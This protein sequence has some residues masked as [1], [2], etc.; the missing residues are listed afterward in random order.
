[1]KKIF[2]KAKSIGLTWKLLFS[3]MLVTMFVVCFL[4]VVALMVSKNILVS[5]VSQYNLE[6][7]NQ[8]RNSVELILDYM[9]ERLNTLYVDDSFMSKFKLYCN[10]DKRTYEEEL[11]KS[12]KMLNDY[13]ALMDKLVK[14]QLPMKFD[15]SYMFA[16]TN[17]AVAY[18]SWGKPE[19]DL[20]GFTEDC[21]RLFQNKDNQIIWLT[22]HR[23][24][25][26]STFFYDDTKTFS[27]IKRISDIN[28]LDTLG[29]MVISISEK[30]LYNCYKDLIKKQYG[31]MIYIIDEYGNQV[32]GMY[33]E[34]EDRQ[35][36]TQIYS[37]L[38]NQIKKN[39]GGYFFDDVDGKQHLITFS[40][41][42]RNNWSIIHIMPFDGL[43]AP[44]NFL[45][46]SI[47]IAIMVAFSIALFV[48]FLISKNISKRLNKLRNVMLQQGEDGPMAHIV[49][50]Y[51]DEIGDL[52][53]GYNQM[54]DRINNYSKMLVEEQKKK[55]EMELSFLQIQINSHF[56][57]NTL[58]SIKILARFKMVDK[59][60]GLITSLVKLLKLT[61][62]KTDLITIEQEI[63]NIKHYVYIQKIRYLDRFEVFYDCKPWV[64]EY[65]IPKLLLQP[66]IENAIFHGISDLQEKGIITVLVEKKENYIFIKIRDNG[67]GI[68]EDVLKNV[69]A[70]YSKMNHV[71]LHNIDERVKIYF[72][73]EYGVSIESEVG[74]GTTVTV[75]IGILPVH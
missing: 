20:T 13:Y 4:S 75:K 35:V 29:Y 9:V 70:K 57:Y 2:K 3:N 53:V 46:L 31:T 44:I 12:S 64:S 7:V 11:I 73:Q 42:Y 25:A 59:I 26:D 1:M 16:V 71:G 14:T 36:Y 22:T 62:S 8:V 18:A 33:E 74:K 10:M 50:D 47:V 32:S 68:P 34:K 69:M 24:L 58:N 49:I 65:L 27:A 54:A 21:K 66:I 72:G 52:A 51:K 30:N 61:S 19:K 38:S 23:T 15:G 5:Q 67:M 63:E 37:E 56:L 43:M 40:T 17:E 39:S 41:I 28:Q 60:G 45:R 55:R 6:S 48:S